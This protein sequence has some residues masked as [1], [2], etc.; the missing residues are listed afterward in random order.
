MDTNGVHN[1]QV[2]AAPQHHPSPGVLR[3]PGPLPRALEVALFSPA[4]FSRASRWIVQ[5]GELTL[6][7]SFW[8]LR[9]HRNRYRVKDIIVNPQ[10]R[11]KFHDIALLR[12]ASSVTYSKYIQPVCV[13]SSTFTFLH[14]SDCWVTGWGV[15][16]ENMG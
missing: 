13:L 4:R 1:E 5:L 10:A 7:Q 16:H 2:V 12:L 11:G 8:S 15:I 14:R 6:R 3:W 9:A